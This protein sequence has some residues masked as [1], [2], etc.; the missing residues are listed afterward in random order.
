[1]IEPFAVDV[2]QAVLDDLAHRL[3]A[4]RWTEDFAKEDWCYGV[5]A[6]YAGRVSAPSAAP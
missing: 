1:M 6:A 2:P 4:T 5:N 3:A